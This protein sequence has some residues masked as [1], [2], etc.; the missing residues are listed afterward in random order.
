M[1]NPL[2]P[3]NSTTLVVEKELN[4]KLP[5]EWEGVE[6]RPL[7]HVDWQAVKPK[8]HSLHFAWVNFRSGEGVRFE[9]RR[10]QGYRKATQADCDNIM[11][12]D[13][14][15]A[16]IRGDLILMCVDKAI[17]IAADKHN[18]MRANGAVVRRLQTEAKGMTS[19][20]GK[21]V[22]YIP[23]SAEVAKIVDQPAARK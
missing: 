21:I 22:G 16:F 2:R 11:W 12:R 13:A 9:T 15:K 23:E 18:F 8:N 4:T 14:D 1:S 5:A 10:E 20:D 17:R 6:A 7:G 19:P 3:S